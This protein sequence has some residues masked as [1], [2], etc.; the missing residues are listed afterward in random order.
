MAKIK[1]LPFLTQDR[2][3]GVFHTKLAT[4]RAG[5]GVDRIFDKKTARE[6][7]YRRGMLLWAKWRPRVRI[8]KILSSF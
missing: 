6:I 4:A 1:W 2:G 7:L 5:R 8:T 3:E